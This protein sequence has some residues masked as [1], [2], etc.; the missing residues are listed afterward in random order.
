MKSYG[1]KRITNEI[2]HHKVRLFRNLDKN[3]I[4]MLG[5]WVETGNILVDKLTLYV[6]KEL[7]YVLEDRLLRRSISKETC[8]KLLISSK[9]GVIDAR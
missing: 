3:R 6:T 4:V 5:S 1:S 7:S 2:P 9:S 8:L